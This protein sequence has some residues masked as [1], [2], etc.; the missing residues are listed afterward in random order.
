MAAGYAEKA[1][2]RLP[3]GRDDVD[4]RPDGLARLPDKG[5]PVRRLADSLRGAGD[6]EVELVA[7]RFCDDRAQGADRRHCRRSDLSGLRDLRPQ[8]RHL[9]VM[10]D[11]LELPTNNV[12][13][14]G[15]HRVAP[16]VDCGQ[17]HPSANSRIWR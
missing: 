5:V 16:D 17:T 4:R 8:L 11:V 2:L 1:E 9:D 13:D 12:G 15:M 10:R 6:Q 7:A 14:E 3:P